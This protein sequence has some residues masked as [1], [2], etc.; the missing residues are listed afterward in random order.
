M[1][2]LEVKGHEKLLSVGQDVDQGVLNGG[3]QHGVH[4]VLVGL[5]NDPHNE[6]GNELFRNRHKEGDTV[7]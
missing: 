5:L 6:V 2:A 1:S 4:S 7:H 3:L